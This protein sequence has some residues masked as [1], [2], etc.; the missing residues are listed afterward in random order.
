MRK[1]KSLLFVITLSVA[2]IVGSGFLLSWTINDLYGAS[3]AFDTLSFALL[4]VLIFTIGISTMGLSLMGLSI[5][6]G[7]VR[8]SQ[9]VYIGVQIAFL[10]IASG[11]LL[12]CFNTEA[13]NS[14]W[15]IFFFSWQM[16]LFVAGVFCFFKK[17]FVTGLILAVAGVFFL[18]E[19]ATVL[20]P[21]DIQL[22]ILRSN[23]WPVIFI[24][25]GISFFIRFIIRPKG[26]RGRYHNGNRIDEPVPG[27]NDNENEDGKINYRFVFSGTEQVILDPVFKGG[28]IDV[29]FGGVA[30]DLRRT[31]LAEGKTFLYINAMIG[32]V[33]MKVPDTWDIEIQSKS[34]IGGVSDSRTKHLDIDHTRKLVIISKCTLGGI[35]IK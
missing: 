30:L 23:I 25:T 5:R 9:D 6:K 4:S 3:P 24:V 7:N 15:R 13:L 1:N 12:F 31:S 11:I 8:R 20:Y 35:E 28:T 2:L 10:L 29:T 27:E 33:E 34:T 18:I 22:D 32:G 26:C 19:K 14:D 17:H 16:L 21:S